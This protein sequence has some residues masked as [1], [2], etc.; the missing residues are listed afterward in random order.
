MF[1]K[2]W[3]HWKIY[4]G[5]IGEFQSRLLLSVFY[6][7]VMLPFGVFARL[8][9]KSLDLNFS[10]QRKSGWVKREVGAETLEDAAQHF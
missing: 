3:E 8:F 1:R 4:A 7:T 2:L 9:D 10:D 5:F 6:F